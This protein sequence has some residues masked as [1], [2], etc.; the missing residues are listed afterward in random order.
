MPN[1][2]GIFTSNV[3]GQFQKAGFAEDSIEEC[4]G[5]IH[6]LQCMRPCT[7]AI[8]RADS[9]LPEVDD[10]QCTLKNALPACPHCGGLARPNI[11]MFGDGEWIAD[12]TDA[13]AKRLM[14]RLRTARRPVVVEIGAGSAIASVRSF[15]HALVQQH[16]GRLVR[17][18]PT[19]SG[20]PSQA[21]AGLAC[22]G[23]EG[24]LAIDAIME[25]ATR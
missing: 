8:W 16:H 4:H 17:I 20:V 21:E 2:V 14:V 22:R 11:L 7:D 3:D 15:S 13:Q 5:S 1:G 18:N 10:V 25:K 19:E 23:L 24:L 6:H 9:F 12:R